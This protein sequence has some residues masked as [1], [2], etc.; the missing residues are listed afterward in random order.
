MKRKNFWLLDARRNSST[1]NRKI[2]K[3]F[4]V[5]PGRKC[6]ATG[7]SISFYVCECVYKKAEGG[8]R[9]EDIGNWRKKSL[10]TSSFLICHP[11]PCRLSPLHVLPFFNGLLLKFTHKIKILNK[12]WKNKFYREFCESRANEGCSARWIEKNNPRRSNKKMAG[13]TGNT[14]AHI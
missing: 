9:A 10:M 7:Q 3:V 13:K 11:T 4:K 2:R 1:R 14:T 6:W 12:V 5:G 8:G